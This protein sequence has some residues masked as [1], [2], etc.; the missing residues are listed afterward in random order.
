MKTL[1]EILIAATLIAVLLF[2]AV[3][4][5]TVVK[6]LVQD[7]PFRQGSAL[8]GLKAGF[9][10]ATTTE[11]GPDETITIFTGVNSSGIKKQCSSRVISTTDGSNTPITFLLGDPTNGDIASTS[12]TSVIG[13]YQAG[14]TTQAYDSG[15]YGCD[16][17]TAYAT[18]ST[19]LTVTEFE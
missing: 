11:V 5:T 10:V 16:R 12:L 14:S 2:A 13:Q 17:W 8:P 18:A 15:L 3:A 19:T 1:K 4:T 9:G 6:T 7:E